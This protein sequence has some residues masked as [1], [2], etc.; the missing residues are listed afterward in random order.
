MEILPINTNII[1]FY[2]RFNFQNIMTIIKDVFLEILIKNYL[3]SKNTWKLN[4]K[5]L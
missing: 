5:S 2:L 4:T 3:L 1:I